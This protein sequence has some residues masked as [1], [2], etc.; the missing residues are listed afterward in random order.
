MPI[1]MR[2]LSVHYELLGRPKYTDTWVGLR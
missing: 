1:F 2:A